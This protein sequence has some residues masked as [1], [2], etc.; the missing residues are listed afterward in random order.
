M[1]DREQ[2][3][4]SRTKRTWCTPEIIQ[5]P[6]RPEEAVLGNCKITSVT[7]PGGASC[8]QT[9]NCFTIGS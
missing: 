7:G 2:P 8:S 6:L 4:P 3:E 9:G 5:V 1:N